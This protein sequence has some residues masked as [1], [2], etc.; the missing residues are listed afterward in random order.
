MQIWNVF[1]ERLDRNVLTG[2][3]LITDVLYVLLKKKAQKLD[4]E[5]NLHKL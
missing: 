4:I 2:N 5:L 3:I 1:I